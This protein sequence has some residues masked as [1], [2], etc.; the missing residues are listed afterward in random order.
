MPNIKIEIHNR[1]IAPRKESLMSWNISQEEK[2]A[3]L[4][5]L[6]ELALGKVNKGYK[7]S[8]SR[9]SKYLDVLR[10]PL[11]FFKKS[12]PKITLKDVENFERALCTGQIKSNKGE[13]YSHSTQVDIRRALQ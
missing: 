9:Q 1:S 13:A 7:I 10:T 8:E 11:E 6:D 2:K 5:F 12:T 4:K 3:I